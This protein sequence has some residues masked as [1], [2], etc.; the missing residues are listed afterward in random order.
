M[1]RRSSYGDSAPYDCIVDVR[2][3]HLASAGEGGSARAKK[4]AVSL[5]GEADPGEI[6]PPV[7]LRA[8]RST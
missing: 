3:R 2:G 1:A 4:Y 8:L 7:V 5:R 6:Q